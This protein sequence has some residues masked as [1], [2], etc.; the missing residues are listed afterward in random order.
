MLG[1]GYS[2]G[3]QMI[4]QGSSC[5]SDLVVASYGVMV[6]CLLEILFAVY[7][8]YVSSLKSY[9]QLEH[10]RKITVGMILLHM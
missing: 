7:F 2:H 5:F 6:L 3:Y 10:E 8:L 4:G 1:L 9:E